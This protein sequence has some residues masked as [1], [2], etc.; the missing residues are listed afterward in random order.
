MEHRPQHQAI[1]RLSNLQQA[2]LQSVSAHLQRRRRA[3]KAAVVPYQE[4][5]QTVAADKSTVTTHLCQLLRQ[6]LVQ[7]VLP[8]GGWTRCVTLTEQGQDCVRRFSAEK[9]Q[10]DV[11]PVVRASSAPARSE[12][13][14]RPPTR[15]RDAHRARPREKRHTQQRFR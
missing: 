12:K 2:I 13:R 9:R 10:P 3:G 15:R 6:G 5:V 14:Q 7:L 4:I 1:R 8:P 11:T